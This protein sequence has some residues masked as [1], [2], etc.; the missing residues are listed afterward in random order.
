MSFQSASSSSATACAN[1]VPTC[2]PISAFSM[3]TVTIPPRSTVY[4]TVGEKLPAANASP[5]LPVTPDNNEKPQVRPAP[6]VTVPIRNWRRFTSSTACLRARVLAISRLLLAGGRA[7]HVLGGALDRLLDPDIGHAATEIAVHR[8]HDLRVGGIGVF[9]QEGCC[10]HDLPRLAPAAL[11]HLLG[12]P[13][14][15]Y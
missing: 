15:L 9:A 14:A 1:A 8:L 10:L 3:C 4:Q 12:D 7:V 2:W 6:A 5:A 11:R 13:G